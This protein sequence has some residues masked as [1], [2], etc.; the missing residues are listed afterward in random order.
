MSFL[1]ADVQ[2]ALRML[3]ADKEAL[4]QE[5]ERMTPEERAA[6]RECMERSEAEDLEY[7]RR[8]GPLLEEGLT[9]TDSTVRLY[10]EDHPGERPAGKGASDFLVAT[11]KREVVVGDSKA[12]INLVE[13]GDD[14]VVRPILPALLPELRAH[15]RGMWDEG[16]PFHMVAPQMGHGPTSGPDAVV[17]WERAALDRCSL[18]WVAADMVEVLL[19]AAASVPDDVRGNDLAPLDTCGLV[20]LERPWQGTSSTPGQRT[21]KVD[22]FLW[23][24]TILL[25]LDAERP[26]LPAGE[27]IP[28]VSLSA[29]SC[30]PPARG[31]SSP[32]ARK[33]ALDEV[34]W[35]PLGRSDWP[36][37]DELG[38]APWPMEEQTRQSFA[39]DRKILCALMTLLAHAG[40]AETKTGYAPRGVRRRLERA[41]GARDNSFRI[42]TLRHL[43]EPGEETGNEPGEGIARD[44]RWIV[45]GHWRRQPYGRRDLNLR[46]LQW[47]H[48]HVKGPEDAPIKMK[49]IIHAWRR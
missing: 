45:S 22:A 33:Y 7:L 23:G 19:A 34:L 49:E 26:D 30:F 31:L 10:R 40:I 9:I 16:R 39:E 6:L 12:G 8:L 36:L 2:E 27:G 46:R 20:A 24:P 37:V 5:Q 15:L 47:I 28:A 32:I 25:P 21:V 1:E 48:P 35:A 43:R 18:W 42:V 3:L 41:H 4:V 29:Y 14:A 13:L 17:Q 44:H 38:R 11:G